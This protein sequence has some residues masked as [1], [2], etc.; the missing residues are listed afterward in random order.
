MRSDFWYRL[1]MWADTNN[2]IRRVELR[3]H[4]VK[5]GS[6]SAKLKFCLLHSCDSWG[7]PRYREPRYFSHFAPLLAVELSL[8]YSSSSA[9]ATESLGQAPPELLASPS[10]AVPWP[11]ATGRRSKLSRSHRG[12]A[13][14]LLRG[15]SPVLAISN[16]PLVRPPP[17]W[18]SRRCDPGV[19]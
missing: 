5:Y 14:S 2:E 15:A 19:A 16:H 17:P 8:R 1:V 4:A 7:P 3:I 9:T 11:Q 10:R 18:G 12:S 6:Q 13:S